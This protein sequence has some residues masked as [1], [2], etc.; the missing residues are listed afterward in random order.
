MTEIIKRLDNTAYDFV[1]KQNET[2]IEYLLP[3]DKDKLL[4]LNEKAE[5]FD[6]IYVNDCPA[7]FCIAFR[8]GVEEYDLKGYKEF[9]KYY[10][11]YLYV[12][13]IVIDEKFQGMGLGRKLY[14]NVFNLAEKSG[15]EA[16]TVVI[17]TMPCNKSSLK[18]HEKMGFH[19]IG[20]LLLRGGCV[21]ASQWVKEIKG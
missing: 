15:V 9:S 1:L 7:G 14:Q 8:E 17:T 19:E 5:L 4:F 21:K 20:E 18:F 2:H 6:V 12:D 16:V 13:T 10:S 3:M 11:K